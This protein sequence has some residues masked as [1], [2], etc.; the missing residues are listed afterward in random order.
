MERGLGVYHTRDLENV[1]AMQEFY[2]WIFRK[3]HGV[4]GLGW[5]GLGRTGLD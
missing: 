3:D 4:Y 2:G 5:T 1:V